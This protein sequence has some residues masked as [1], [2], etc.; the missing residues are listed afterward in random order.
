V[1]AERHH[2]TT[3]VR[4][5]PL[6]LGLAT[7]L[8]VA[9]FGTAYAFDPAAGR[10]NAPPSILPFNANYLTALSIGYYKIS[11]G[12]LI[13]IFQSTLIVGFVLWL[14]SR[15]RPCPGMVTLLLLIGNVPAAAAFTNQT[16][17]LA[18]TIAQALVAG[19]LADTLVMRFDPHPVPAKMEAFYW[20][21]AAI[22]MTYI[23]VY[24]IGMA[25]HEGI[26]WDWNVALGSWIWS[27]VCGFALS[28]LITSR[29]TA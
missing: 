15:I 27:G 9:H 8:I 25:I 20:F 18:I 10:T 11:T 6:V 29:R 22:P 23:G 2:A 21:A 28:L 14:V 13:V 12:A 1:L 5:L 19:L 3:L 17:L 4:Q 26:W 16:P 7:W 24:L